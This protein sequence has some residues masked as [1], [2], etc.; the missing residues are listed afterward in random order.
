MSERYPETEQTE[1]S[2]EGT[3]AH[4]VMAQ[5]IALGGKGLVCDNA[6]MQSG[7]EL[8]GNNVFA[9]TQANP[10]GDL[11]VEQPVSIATI[12][13][14]CWGTPDVSYFLPGNLWLWDY[15]FGHGFVEVF[16]NWQL[17]EYAAGLLDLYQVNGI[18]DQHT[19]VHMRIVQPRCYH[20]E[21]QIREWK[22]LASDLRGRF[23]QAR[24]FEAKATQ[25]LASLTVSEE[26][27]YCPARHACPALQHAALNACDRSYEANPFDLPPEAL[28]HEAATLN[29]SL[30]LLQARLT[31][32]EA[33]I[34]AKL[35]A[36]TFVPHWALGRGQGKTQWRVPKEQ[37][38]A[39]GDLMGVDLRK[40]VDV[41]TPKQAKD[42]KL[43]GAIVDQMSEF[44]QGAVKVVPMD[45]SLAARVFDGNVNK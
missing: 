2:K 15:K 27:D 7:A 14:D 20:P 41:I 25:E 22:I 40:P 39:F 3:A 1:A 17:I 37:V 4:E 16:E 5:Y 28:G 26:C 13:P 32:L 44:I 34:E 21:G 45:N 10:N 35:R 6:E 42:K 30:S 18:A 38:A 8:I 12:H 29:R 9:V 23:N 19:M 33:Q 36:G 24:N 31:G 43:D 11:R